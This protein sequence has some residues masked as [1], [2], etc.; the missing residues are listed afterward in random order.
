MATAQ[1][2]TLEY[3]SGQTQFPLSAL[4]DSG[5]HLTFNGN[6]DLF[7]TAPGFTPVIRPNGVITG[8]GAVAPAASTTADMVDAAALS[9]YLAGLK[10]AVAASTDKAVTRGAALNTHIINS[11]TVTSA[12]AIA[13]VAGTAAPAHTETRGAAGGPPFIPVGSIELAQ[14]RLTSITAAAITASEIV[15]IPGLH[16]ERYDYPIFEE[17]NATGNVIFNALLPLIHTGATAKKVYA[18]YAE[19]VFSL[20]ASVSDFVAP[21]ESYSSSSKQIYSGTVG[22]SSRSL[23]QGSFTAYLKSGVSDNLIALNGKELW[24][25]FTPNKYQLE[26]ILCHGV[27]GISRTFPAA[28]NITAKCTISAFKPAINKVA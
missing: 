12:G 8:G 14:V 16:L 4:T 13:I 18:S 9:G 3:E 19:P 25:K 26:H 6:G 22:S 20:I 17:N 15:A 5:D 28:D 24:F 23:G 27:F 2:A 10:T 1:D 21:E 11:I 7:S